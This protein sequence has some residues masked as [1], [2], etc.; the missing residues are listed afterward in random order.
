MIFNRTTRS[1]AVSRRLVA[2]TLA[3]T[4]GISS[5]L[6]VPAA[7]YAET[8]DELAAQVEAAEQRLGELNHQLEAAQAQVDTTEADLAD[9]RARIDALQQEIAQNEEELSTSQVELADQAS[10]TYKD[11][12]A[13]LVDIIF[14][15]SSL[16][17]FVS[18]IFYA[19]RVASVRS[20]KIAS[21]REL[22][23]T[24]E[25][26]KSDLSVEEEQLTSLLDQQEQSRAELESATIEASEYV[27]GLSDELQAAL[28]A[29]REAAAEEARR[30]AAAQQAELERQQ[31]QERLE[32][33]QQQQ[34]QQPQTPSNSGNTGSSGSSGNTGTV[35]VP[36]GG[37]SGNLTASQRQA[38]VNA[39]LSQIGVEYV[40]GA[41]NPG[42]ALDCSGLTTYSYSQAG[43]SITRSSAL[44]YRQV[45]NAGNL[46]MSTSELQPGDLVFYGNPNISHVGIYI[47]GGQIVHANGYG[48]GVM[49][50]SI[51]YSRNFRGGGSPI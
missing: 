2:L 30:Q 25:T 8:T 28:D 39:G 18:R 44:Q 46:T 5:A 13:T 22:Q 19:N 40:F 17:D 11:G 23:E 14:S 12:G 16:S 49:I 32:Q 21:V 50:S 10:E 4:L 24:L 48:R 36:S 7:V 26:Q 43:L 51:N 41:M 34:E 9:T 33:E 35:E 1:L 31:E 45:V 27:E 15:S 3:G 42:V 6:S 38:I 29:E 47:G 37:G 20:E